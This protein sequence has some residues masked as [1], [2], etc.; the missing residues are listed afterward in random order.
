MVVLWRQGMSIVTRIG[1]GQT[2]YLLVQEPN[3]TPWILAG[4]YASPDTSL[5]LQ[6]WNE[7]SEVIKAGLPMLLGGDYNTLLGGMEKKRGA[8]FRITPATIR[9]QEWVDNN[10]LQELAE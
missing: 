2:L 6:M 1:N 8:P 10:H 7:T 3:I 4:V 9:F 5:R